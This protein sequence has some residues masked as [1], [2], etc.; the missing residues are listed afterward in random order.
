M[1]KS[2]ASLL[3]VATA[4]EMFSFNEDASLFEDAEELFKEP[5]PVYQDNR[6]F[7]GSWSCITKLP[8]SKE[9]RRMKITFREHEDGDG[10]RMIGD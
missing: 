6:A 1:F 3:A 9:G 7:I 2:L 4:N 10:L 5:F 8:K